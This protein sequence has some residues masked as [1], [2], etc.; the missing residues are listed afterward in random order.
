MWAFNG[1][2]AYPIDPYATAYSNYYNS[3]NKLTP[4]S[5]EYLL[6]LISEFKF[7]NLSTTK[8]IYELIRLENMVSQLENLSTTKKELLTNKEIHQIPA[9]FRNNSIENYLSILESEI[10]LSIKKIL[11]DKISEL[12]VNDYSNL[13]IFCSYQLFRSKKKKNYFLAHQVNLGFRKSDI[14]TAHLFFNLLL[15]EALY[16]NLIEK[17]FIITI[18]ENKTELN[19]ITSDDPS[20]NHIYKHK[21]EDFELLIPLS[22]KLLMKCSPNNYTNEYAIK[23]REYLKQNKNEILFDKLI[24]HEEIFDLNFISNVNKIIYQ[25]KEM[26]VYGNSPND[27]TTL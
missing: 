7:E 13:I 15:S 1:K 14:E 25:N 22:P 4:M 2:R 11:L 5:I 3:I 21:K 12:D 10:S 27:F 6:K 18:F 9:E 23:L 16:I 8:I 26:L 24:F 20:F 19:F 17:L